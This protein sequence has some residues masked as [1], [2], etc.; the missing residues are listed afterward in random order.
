MAHAS[1]TTDT[2]ANGH[3]LQTREVVALSVY[4]LLFFAALGFVVPFIPIFLDARGLSL[5]EIAIVITTGAVVGALTQGPLGHLSDSLG[6]RRHLAVFSCVSLGASYLFYG[7][8]HETWQ[9][10][11]L[12][13]WSGAGLLAGFTLPQAIIADWTSASGSTARGFSATRIW[14]TVGFV[15]S[16][17][18]VTALP[19]IASTTAFLYCAAGLY[20]ACAFPLLATREAPVKATRLSL[21]TGAMRVLASDRSYVFLFCFTIFRLC[22]SGTVNYLG[23][24]VKGM[25]GTGSTVAMTYMIAACAEMPIMLLVGRVS[26][27]FGR[28]A[29]LILAF[30][31][32]PVRLYLYSLITV[33]SSIYYIQLL[34]GFTYGIV[35]IV[36]VAYMSD[37]A[38]SDLRAT[39]QGLLSVASAVA[40]AAGPLLVGFVGDAIGLAATFEVMA[41]LAVFALIILVAF[42]Q[43]PR[44][45]ATNPPTS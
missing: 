7:F 5:S 25:G 27:R 40:L 33:P 41:A 4:F 8:A 45:P 29:P 13:A 1:D 31:I 15:G 26:D 39:A 12:A 17:V 32:W 10:A 11:L 18:C 21:L 44:R 37:V 30:A 16:L 28:K 6:A 43:E 23:L 2:V 24:Y 35:L 34:H 38:A 42:V 19:S 20:A 3:G 36:S 22:E 14:G 9:F